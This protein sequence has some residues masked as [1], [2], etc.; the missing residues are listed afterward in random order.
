MQMNT[1]QQHIVDDNTGISYTLSGEQYYPNL[2]SQ[3]EEHNSI[4]IFGQERLNYLKH[5]RRL[6]YINLLTSGKLYSHL[7]EIEESAIDQTELLVKQFA[8]REDITEK[9]KIR[10]PMLWVQKM[11]N[12]R[13]R[14]REIVRDSLIYA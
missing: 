11:N 12:I 10:D 2:V 9:L 13:N 1:L 8:E 14:V 6:L 7:N 4:G 3:G 5:H